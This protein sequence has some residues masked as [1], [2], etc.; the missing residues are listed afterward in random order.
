ML[1]PRNPQHLALVFDMTWLYLITLSHAMHNIRA[2]HVANPDRGLQEYLFG[3]AI[4]L[5]EKE[6]LSRMLAELREA[7]AMPS[8]VRVEPLPTYYPKMLELVVRVMRRPDRVLPA[9]R[10]LEVLTAVS[11]IGRRGSPTEPVR[12]MRIWLPSRHPT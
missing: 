4:G 7:G 8:E 11:A 12:F 5:R 3:G 2:A 1:D 10:L 6:A 9:L